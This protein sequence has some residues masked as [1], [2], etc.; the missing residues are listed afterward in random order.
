MSRA[1][2]PRDFAAYEMNKAV[3]VL[4]ELKNA[5]GQAGALAAASVMAQVAIAAALL[6]VAEAIRSNRAGDSVERAMDRMTEA[7]RNGRPS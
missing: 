2:P 4:N 5:Q 7:M 1:Q 3:G 6:D